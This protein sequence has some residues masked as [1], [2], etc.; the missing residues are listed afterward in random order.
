M[1]WTRKYRPK[2]SEDIQAQSKQKELIKDFL[3]N[4]KHYKKKS[5]FIYGSPGCGKTSSVY[6]IANELNLEIIEVNAS[7]YRTP[8]LLETQVGMA[9]KQ[10]SL[11][12]NSKVILIDEVDGMS[13]TKDRGGLSALAKIIANSSFPII[14]TAND[15]FDKKYSGLRKIS[16]MVQFDT[17]RYTS[18]Y[19]CLKTICDSENISIEDNDLKSLARHAGGDLRGAIT[20]LQLLAT[21]TDIIEKSSLEELGERRQTESMISALMKVLKTTDPSVA[22]SAFDAVV[23][24]VDKQMLWLD[25]NMPVEYT[26]PNDLFRAYE[27]LAKADIYKRRIRR[28]QHWRYLVYINQL[29]TAGI[30][31][32]KD[33]KYEGY[34]PYKPTT[35]I[36]KL[37]Q[38]KMKYAKKN[39]VAKKIASRSHASTSD[40]IQSCLPYLQ[41]IAHNDLSQCDAI[42]EECD[43]NQEERDW[44]SKGT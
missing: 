15:A 34:V 14:L 39:E 31:L 6:A 42:G 23:E 9:S 17:L 40:I 43:L 16:E 12:G 33:Q 7:D 4:W 44:L 35:R 25:Q 21:G 2:S 36:L 29:L 27:C 38:A 19:T 20:D 32:S 26:K 11:F 1:P 30:S 24:D 28:W 10:R 5:L 18:I 22:L 3:Q 37:W 41:Q 13:G 8:S